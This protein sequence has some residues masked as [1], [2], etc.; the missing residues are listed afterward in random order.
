M[1]YIAKV[2]MNRVQPD[3]TEVRIEAGERLPFEPEPWLVDGG[4]VEAVAEAPPLAPP[5]EEP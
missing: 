3:G 4:Y 1:A 2:G 5:E